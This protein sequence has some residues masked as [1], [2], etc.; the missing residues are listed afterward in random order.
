MLLWRRFSVEVV[1]Q[2]L[3]FPKNNTLYLQIR[4]LG[5]CTDL[6]ATELVLLQFFSGLF[7]RLDETKY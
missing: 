5:D 1:C 3:P 7:L 4:C 2:S 6:L